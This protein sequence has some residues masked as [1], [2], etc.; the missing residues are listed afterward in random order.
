ME[1]QT[2]KMPLPYVIYKAANVHKDVLTWFIYNIS[3]ANQ[4]G[5]K[6]TSF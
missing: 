1:G 2:L 4:A 3:N 5:Y 6:F